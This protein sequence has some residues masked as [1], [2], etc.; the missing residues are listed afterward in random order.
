MEGAFSICALAMETTRGA[1][2]AFIHVCKSGLG[3]QKG[4]TGAKA[5]VAMIGKGLKQRTEYSRIKKFCGSGYLI[6]TRV[7]G[8]RERL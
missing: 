6:S 1:R 4:F 2:T 7:P 5:L 8:T 3:T